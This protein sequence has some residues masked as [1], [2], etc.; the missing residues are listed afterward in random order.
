MRHVGLFLVV[1]GAYWLPIALPLAIGLRWRP[2]QSATLRQKL[3]LL[4]TLYATAPLALFTV[5]AIAARTIFGELAQSSVLMSAGL[6]FVL[7]LFGLAILFL[8]QVKLSWLQLKPATTT[9]RTIAKAVCLSGALAIGVG[10]IEEVIFRVFLIDQLSSSFSLWLSAIISSLAFAF[11]HLIWDWRNT[12]LQLP[13]L[14][15]MGMVL[16][17]AYTVDGFSVGLPWGLH[18]GWIFGMA[19]SEIWGALSPTGQ[20][21]LWITGQE[22]LPLTGVGSLFFLLGTAGTLWLTFH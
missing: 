18:S 2:F 8:V 3:P 12:R 17:L 21:S 13:G 22:G 11:L 19:L 7:G 6:G 4:L 10:L 5:E 9:A 20:V 15:L 1:W 16:A 14:W